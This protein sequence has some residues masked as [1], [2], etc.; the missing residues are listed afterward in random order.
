MFI[1]IYLSQLRRLY[2]TKSEMDA[3]FVF[4][5]LLILGF[6]TGRTRRDLSSTPIPAVLTYKIDL[7]TYVMQNSKCPF[8]GY[9]SKRL[10]ML[11][12]CLKLTNLA[13]TF[14]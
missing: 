10:T 2:I 12:D 1:R 6:L 13:K 11:P 14:S 9:G 4:F 3:Y 5:C 8:Y 7:Q